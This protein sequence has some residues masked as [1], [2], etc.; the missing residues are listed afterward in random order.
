MTHARRQA[1]EP[2]LPAFLGSFVFV[3]LALLTYATTP[4][5]PVVT[6]ISSILLAGVTIVNVDS[7]RRHPRPRPSWTVRRVAIV[8]AYG[9]G[10]ILIDFYAGLAAAFL[11]NACSCCVTGVLQAVG[12][13]DWF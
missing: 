13:S 4:P 9:V 6:L 1:K 5:R 10:I 2:L 11:V 12:Y 3:V 7:S 8:F